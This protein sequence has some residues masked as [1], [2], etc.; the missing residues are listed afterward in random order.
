MAGKQDKTRL[1]WAA[2]A[3]SL[4][5][6]GY[7][8]HLQ[9]RIITCPGPMEYREGA[10]VATTALLQRGGDPYAVENLPTYMN[11]YSI[12]YNVVVLPVAKVFG[13]GFVTHRT[14]SS[15]L[16]LCCGG[17]I[18]LAL[19]HAGVS[20]QL[21]TVAGVLLCVD[22]GARITR[23]DPFAM[24][25]SSIARPDAMAM[26]LFLVS[27]LVPWRGGWSHRSM[28]IG[29][30]AGVAAFY[31]KPYFVIGFPM[32]AAFVVLFRSKQLGL[33]YG[34]GFIVLLAASLFTATRISPWY[35][36]L[37]IRGNI[38]SIAPDYLHLARQI[39]NFVI[40]RPAT[41]AMLFV[42]G[43]VGI[44][45]LINLPRSKVFAWS[46]DRPLLNLPA[47][48][49]WFAAG[50]MLLLL[51]AKMGPHVGNSMVYFHQLLTP[52]V[53][54]II[55]R[56]VDR[57]RMVGKLWPV[58]FLLVDLAITAVTLPKPPDPHTERWAEWRQIIDG[59]QNIYAPAPLA[60]MISETGKPLYE[61]GLSEYFLWAIK[62]EVGPSV[63]PLRQRYQVYIDDLDRQVCAEKFDLIVLPVQIDTRRPTFLK[64]DH[65]AQHYH[66]VGTLEFPMDWSP[67]FGGMLLLP[68]GN[69]GKHP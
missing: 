66:V 8:L 45:R 23:M 14:V 5:I 18:L 16:M 46:L 26:L 15:I 3:L 6:L 31:T 11:T 54:L 47:D 38:A 25:F 69:P 19:R 24:P 39:W 4:G 21:A 57:P 48:F 35:V 50:C 1:L 61:N 58:A 60:A 9:Y 20:I 36:E 22:L 55:I 27:V 56:F 28:I 42:A 2:F 51:V 32:V 53:L 63:E 10:I 68:K 17:A 43:Y 40:T 29:L 44:S 49:P 41:I 59:K 33:I 34:V 30:L 7:V 12:G 64:T 13:G 52:F 67:G 62:P 37:L 65:V